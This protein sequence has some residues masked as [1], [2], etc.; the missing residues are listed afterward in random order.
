[1]IHDTFILLVS[2]STDILLPTLGLGVFF[3]DSVTNEGRCA[4]DNT[5]RRNFRHL[6]ASSVDKLGPRQLVV[7]LSNRYGVGW[8]LNGGYA[9]TLQLVRVIRHGLGWYCYMV[10]G[11][12]NELCLRLLLLVQI[13]TIFFQVWYFI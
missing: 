9:I 8:H 13:L 11:G 1:M 2:P 4:G 7:A 3:P 12:I 10:S 5:G 6:T